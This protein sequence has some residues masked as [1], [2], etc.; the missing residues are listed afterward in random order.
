[1][2]RNINFLKLSNPFIIVSLII[3]TASL[4]VI[5]YFK[6]FN[7]GTDFT[8]GLELQVSFEKNINID[9]V[10]QVFIDNKIESYKIQP[11][12]GNKQ[13][14]F[15]RLSVDKLTQYKGLKDIEKTKKIKGLL[16]QQLKDYGLEYDKSSLVGSLMSKGNQLAA[17][18]IILI[19][20][21]VE[22]LYLTI[23]FKFF[24]SVSAMVA[25]VHDVIIMLGAISF[26]GKEVDILTISA[27]LTILGYSVNDTIILFDRIRENLKSKTHKDI[28]ELINMSINQVL[29]RTL[30]TSLTTF[31]VVMLL[32]IFVQGSLKNFSFALIV[33]IISGTYSSIY[34]AAFCLIQY[35]KFK[36]ITF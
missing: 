11:I 12:I 31:I 35:N 27:I 24:F 36:R 10:R 4:I 3:I 9:K 8:G 26:F 28:K 16:F 7:L 15:I 23:R 2:K 20:I 32:F 22:I 1:M 5:F 6:G 33:G 30:I 13:S 19:A 34:V 17:L 21:L 29:S 14:Y 18:K 25:L